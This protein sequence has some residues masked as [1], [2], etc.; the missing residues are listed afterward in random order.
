ME[1]LQQIQFNHSQTEVIDVFEHLRSYRIVVCK[2]CKYA[3]MPGH[4][5]VHLA[6]SNHRMPTAM[7]KKIQQ[8]I[9]EL[10]GLIRSDTEL[11]RL[12]LPSNLLK[13]LDCLT[14]Y[15]NGRKCELAGDDDEED[16]CGYICRDRSGMQRHC[17][18][19]HQWVNDWKRGTAHL[20][21]PFAGQGI[22]NHYFPAA[23]C[24]I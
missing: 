21:T 12:R 2:K 9:A 11:E 6:G 10:P 5:E 15:A 14:T 17:R 4:V 1:L 20:M 8:E 19:Q 7:R 22:N 18:Q 24:C 23:D 16:I 13:P 3:V